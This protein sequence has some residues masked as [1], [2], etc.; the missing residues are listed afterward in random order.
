MTDRLLLFFV[1]LFLSVISV[2]F[3]VHA[4]EEHKDDF[5]SSLQQARATEITERKKIT[6]NNNSRSVM[7]SG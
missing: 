2:V 1:I 6:K 7:D 5:L 3:A 4:E